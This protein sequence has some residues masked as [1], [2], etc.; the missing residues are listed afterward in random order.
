M[1]LHDSESIPDTILPPLFG[2]FVV[3]MWYQCGKA[4][5]SSWPFS[6]SSVSTCWGPTFERPNRTATESPQ[7]R[8]DTALPK[9]RSQ[10]FRCVAQNPVASDTKLW[11]T[12][13]VITVTTVT[14]SLCVSCVMHLC[15]LPSVQTAASNW[16][17]WHTVN[18]WADLHSPMGDISLLRRFGGTKHQ[19]AKDQATKDRPRHHAHLCRMARLESS[20]PCICAKKRERGS[21][22]TLLF[23][24]SLVLV[25]VAKICKNDIIL[26]PLLLHTFHWIQTGI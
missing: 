23:L 13:D 20:N 26:I 6:A 11:E 14:T 3:P 25:Q 19:T 10:P 15:L 1:S 24:M 4:P 2:K 9:P 5:W 21:P 18:I 16:R 22:T 7:D 8:S 12:A 17:I